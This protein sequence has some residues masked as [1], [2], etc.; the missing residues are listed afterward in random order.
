M[1][2]WFETDG[3]GNPL[4]VYAWNGSIWKL[5]ADITGLNVA[6]AVSGQSPLATQTPPTYAGNAA[7]VAGGLASGQSYLDSS[8][9]NKLKTVVSMVAPAAVVCAVSTSNT[10]PYSGTTET[11]I[12]SA[13]FSASV[14][15]GGKLRI[16]AAMSGG[17]GD[18][19]QPTSLQLK[20]KITY[21]GTTTVLHTSSAYIDPDG[22]INDAALRAQVASLISNP[23]SGSATITVTRQ[24]QGASSTG[25][26]SY[27]L[28]IL[29]EWV[30]A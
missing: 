27:N 7:A 19:V 16:T 14:P 13:S 3:S 15:S 25:G 9:S 4:K 23:G 26:G 18:G 12:G 21:G 10:A 5:G 30:N 11:T 8:D 6:S 17:I 20:I 24:R 28:D 1:I 22:L 2:S 29:V